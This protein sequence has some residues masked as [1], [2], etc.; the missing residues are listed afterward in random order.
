MMVMAVVIGLGQGFQPL[1][2]FCFGARLIPRLKRAYWFTIAVGTTF[3]IVCTVV[4]WLLSD[5]LIGIFRNDAEVIAVGI[6]AL[7]WQ[8][9]S[10]PLNSMIMTSNMLT[11]TCRMPV[12]ANLLASARSGLFFIPL[13]LILPHFFGLMGVEMCQAVSDVC[14]F[15]LTVPVMAHTLRR[16][17]G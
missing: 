5:H 13:I 14:S 17:R 15:L 6:V 16:L 7:R 2:G 3:L 1:C 12:A 10:L 9:C 4:G 8:L 11:Q